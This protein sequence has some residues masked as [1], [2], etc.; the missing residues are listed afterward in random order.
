VAY[1]F[2]LVAIAKYILMLP[3]EV[4]EEELPRIKPTILKG[5]SDT[6]SASIREAA[7][8]IIIAAQVKLRDETQL[9]ALL[10]GLTETQ[11]HLLTYEFEKMKT[12]GPSSEGE[13]AATELG[14]RKL[15]GRIRH[16]DAVPPPAA[17]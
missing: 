9:F 3:A 4:L 1:C 17:V 10:S 5:L 8:V 14:L 7:Y 13:D 6:T 15:A 11:K 16:L 12:R 2:G